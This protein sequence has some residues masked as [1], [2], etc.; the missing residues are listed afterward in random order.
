MNPE[1]VQLWA[2]YVKMELGFIEGLRRRWNVLGVEVDADPADSKGKRRESAEAED[3][4]LSTEAGRREIM[5]G[6]IVRSVM[7]NGVEGRCLCSCWVPYIN[8]S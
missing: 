7:T 1:D 4:E 5:N 2:E 6:A 3:E 8:H